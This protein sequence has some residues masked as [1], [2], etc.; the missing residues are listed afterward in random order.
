MVKSAAGEQL[1]IIRPIPQ[2][3]GHGSLPAYRWLQHCEVS[4]ADI[5]M[6]SEEASFLL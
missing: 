6:F 2:R 4:Y 5:S 3:V 1:P